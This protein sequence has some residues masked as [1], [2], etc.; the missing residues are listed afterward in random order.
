MYKNIGEVMQENKKITLL[1]DDG[2]EVEYEIKMI[3][4]CNESGKNYAVYTDNTY[5]ENGDLNLYAS[6]LVGE[7]E[8]GEIQLEEIENEEEWEL[9]DKVLESAK[10]GV[11]E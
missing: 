10:E 2:N 11:E 7:D 3:Y 4:L 1:D 6:I 9:L 5:D 8:N